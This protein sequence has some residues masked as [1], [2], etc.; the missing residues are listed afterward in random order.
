MN[1]AT[2]HLVAEP[3]HEE[4]LDAILAARRLAGE[5]P[6]EPE[7]VERLGGGWTADEALAIALFCA[8]KTEG[9]REAARLAVNHSGD[10]DS[11]G[12][13][14][15]QLIGTM[16]GEEGLPADWVERVEG[17]ELLRELADDLGGPELLP[18]P[19]SFWG[20]PVSPAFS[21]KYPGY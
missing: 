8:F 4:V 1:E 2:A 13:L 16:V 10:S 15:G 5:E 18:A 3:D 11:T 12:S 20:S 19:M 14:A 9:F 7:T 6:A 17:V 21:R